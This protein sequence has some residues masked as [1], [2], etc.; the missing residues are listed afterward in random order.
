[1][2]VGG[3]NRRPSVHN[4]GGGGHTKGH[5]TK[6]TSTLTQQDILDYSLNALQKWKDDPNEMAELTQY[7][8]FC[9]I[10]DGGTDLHANQKQI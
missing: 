9:N 5:D 1:M 6:E 7:S 10:N 2:A 4:E 3:R 8:I